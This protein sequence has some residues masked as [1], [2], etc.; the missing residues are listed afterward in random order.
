MTRNTQPQ[1]TRTAD[2]PPAEHA[3]VWLL[4]CAAVLAPIFLG[5]SGIWSRLA[6]ETAIVVAACLWAMSGKRSV[7]ATLLPVLVCGTTLLQLLPL[8]DR[9]LVDLAPVSAGAW[10]LA[11]GGAAH[12]W[13][14]ISV[15]PRGTLCGVQRLFLACAVVAMVTE[16]ARRKSY[17]NRLIASLAMSGA[18]ILVLGFAFGRD[19]GSRVLGVVDLIGPF[20]TAFNPIVRPVQSAGFGKSEWKIVG[21]QR[22]QVDHANV[23][24]GI[25]PYVYSNHFAGAVVLTLPIIC[26]WWLFATRGR[27]HDVFRWGAAILGLAGGIWFTGIVA[28]SR[29]GVAALVFAWIIFGSLAAERPWLRR[30][31]TAAGICCSVALIGLMVA[32]LVLLL[33]PTAEVFRLLPKT[34][35]PGI[36]AALNDPRVIA[37]QIAMRMFFASPLL[38]TGIDSY[39]DVFAR[40]HSSEY[41]L[42]FAHNDYAQLLAETGASGVVTIALMTYVLG[43]RLLTFYF[44][45]RGEYRVLNAGPWAALAG[46]AVHSAFDWN[47]HLPA[48]AFLACVVGGLSASSVPP[49]VPASIRGL[50]QRLPEVL[51]R[52]L[53][54]VAAVASLLFLARD[55]VSDYAQHRI[56]EQLFAPR[57]E[58]ETDIRR[59]GGAAIDNAMAFADVVARWDPGNSRLAMLIGQASLHRGFLADSPEGQGRWLNASAKWFLIAKWA[60]PLGRGFPQQ[61]DT[62]GKH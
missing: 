23:S 16:T 48:N 4:C 49:S 18:L 34:W 20:P 45:A 25:G 53:F 36:T 13:G 2:N 8:P 3:A 19:H 50:A 44:Q 12:A 17:R 31:F 51:P 55:A 1:A 14:R 35:H 37:A 22:Y 32:G 47:L 58:G 33:A 21:T 62:P 41:T 61:V 29:A 10:K 57:F 46:I 9:L 11:T 7:W 24:G 15:N 60:C 52:T 39:Q 6:L 59:H 28:D 43:T 30:L 42:F 38:G 26:A 54:I 27:L 56:R 5:A 40:F